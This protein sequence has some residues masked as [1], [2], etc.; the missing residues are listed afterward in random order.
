MSI[1]KGKNNKLYINIILKKE[2][3]D[4]FHTIYLLKTKNILN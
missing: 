3:Y 1:N 2:Y 4:L